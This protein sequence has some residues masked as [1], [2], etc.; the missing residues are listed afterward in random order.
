MKAV[1]GFTKGLMSM[2]MPWPIW[3]GLSANVCS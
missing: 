1:I 3:L 2:R